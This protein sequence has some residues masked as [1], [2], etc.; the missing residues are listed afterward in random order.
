MASAQA[1]SDAN[2]PIRASKPPAVDPQS[3]PPAQSAD[4]KIVPATPLEYVQTAVLSA[5]EWKGPL[6]LDQYLDREVILQ[7]VDLTKGGRITG[8][9][10][11]SDA[12]PTNSDG[13]RPILACCESIPIHAYIARAGTIDKVQAHGI[14]SVYTRPEHRGKGYAGKMMQELGKRLESWQSTESPNP[15]SVLYSDI[16]QR[17]YARFGWKVF[18]SDHIHLSPLDQKDYDSA[19]TMFPTVQDLPFSELGDI[20]TASYVEERLQILSEERPHTTYVAVRPDREHFEWHFAR[21]EFQSKV[22]GKGFP[23]VKGAIH[24][25]TGL[26]L[27]WCRVYASDKN[28]WLL[29]VL[30]TIVPPTKDTSETYKQAMAAL[31]LRA[32]LEAH[33][34]EMTAGVE[35]W[36]PSD[37]VVASAQQ[38]RT[39]EQDQVQITTRDKEH[40]CSLRWTAGSNDDDLEWVAKE[41]YAWC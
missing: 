26:A 22:L 33:K 3:L 30:H 11:T 8:W 37:L 7:A 13:S 34:W 20:P 29:Q 27:I 35:I 21:D 9:I 12:L 40:L 16:G 38:L 18:P 39:E 28:N 19:S 24:R 36:D 10:L 31:L 32:Q 17:F 2:G 4:L 23:Q 1:Q 14:A 6:T 25:A 41:K 5:D 15:F